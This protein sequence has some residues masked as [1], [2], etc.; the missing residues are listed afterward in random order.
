[1]AG[2]IYLS[3]QLNTNN[4]KI[5]IEY[6]GNKIVWEN[7]Y[8]THGVDFVGDNKIDET[9][10]DDIIEKFAALL[11]AGGWMEQ[12][13]KDTMYEYGRTEFPEEV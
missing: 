11:V 1:M 2:V 13:I 9:P 10:I 8:G 6:Y 4:M 5:T 7:D 3:V 12:T